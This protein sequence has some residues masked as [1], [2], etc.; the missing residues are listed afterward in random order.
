VLEI[1]NLFTIHTVL[2]VS[3]Q[4]KVNQGTIWA[5]GRPG[6]WSAPPNPGA[7][8]LLIQGST[9]RQAEMGRCSVL[10]E[11]DPVPSFSLHVFN[12][13]AN[14]KLKVNVSS[15]GALRKKE[16]VYMITEQHTPNIHFRRTT[17]VLVNFIG[18]L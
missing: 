5:S 12:L 18:L 4:E 6:N 7:G 15:N 13:W 10:H 2:E 1:P 3:P 17:N 14:I 11:N 9:H 8:E 16:R